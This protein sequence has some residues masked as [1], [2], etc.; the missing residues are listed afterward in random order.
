MAYSIGV[1]SSIEP[2]HMVAIQLNTLMADGI[3]IK[4]VRNEKIAP[5]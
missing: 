5:A 2:C 3:A 4:K 1:R